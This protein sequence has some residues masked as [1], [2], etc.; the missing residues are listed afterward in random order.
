M[1]INTY[2]MFPGLAI[3]LFSFLCDVQAQTPSILNLSQKEI[4]DGQG[5]R[6]QLS[7]AVSA[8]TEELE[9]TKARNRRAE[10]R[11]DALPGLRSFWLPLF[12]VT[13]GACCGAC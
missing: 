2:K 11:H 8:Q 9:L 10:H 13:A 12:P 5:D 4:S 7:F 1:K 3:F 6:I